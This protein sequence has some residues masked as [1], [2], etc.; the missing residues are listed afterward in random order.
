MRAIEQAKQMQNQP[1]QR[2]KTE[3][4]TARRKL[5]ATDSDSSFS[6]RFNCVQ[7]QKV[8]NFRVLSSKPMFHKRGT[9]STSKNITVDTLVEFA[10]NH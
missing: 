7:F 1:M 5:A 10:G 8:Q 6:G 2:V 4:K 9:V 3:R